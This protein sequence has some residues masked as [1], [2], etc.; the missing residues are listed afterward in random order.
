MAL[1]YSLVIG[2]TIKYIFR[3]VVKNFEKPFIETM[4]ESSISQLPSRLT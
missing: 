2:L 1:G 3:R 4:S